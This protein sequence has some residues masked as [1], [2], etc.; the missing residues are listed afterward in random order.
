MCKHLTGVEDA[1]NEVYILEYLELVF[2][3]GE[4]YSLKDQVAKL[5]EMSITKKE[6]I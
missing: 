1:Y 5:R 6:A 3:E 4:I 2:N